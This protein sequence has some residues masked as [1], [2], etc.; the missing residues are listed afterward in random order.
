MGSIGMTSRKL[1]PIVIAI[2]IPTYAAVMAPR[3]TMRVT[4]SRPP[5][6]KCA[7]RRRLFAHPRPPRRPGPGRPRR[8]RA[9]PRSGPVVLGQ[10]VLDRNDRVAR[11]P[12]GPQV[13][14][15]TGFERPAL[16]LQS[17]TCRAI[18]PT[19][20]LHDELGRGRVEGDRDLVAGAVARAFDRAEDDF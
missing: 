15:L 7:P 18:L 14:E 9:R 11:G 16:L 17:V 12:V 8:P 5:R 19:R 4:A 20:T 1:T 3:S 13:D 6:P 2:P 10:A